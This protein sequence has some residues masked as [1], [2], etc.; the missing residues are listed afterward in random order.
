[1]TVGSG[2]RYFAIIDSVTGK[3]SFF[4]FTGNTGP[5]LTGLTRL[6][7]A[8][9]GDYS[10]IVGSVTW[11]S[12]AWTIAADGMGFQG[13]TEG[14]I[15]SGSLIIETNAKGVPI[16]RGLGLGE[17]A[18]VAGYGKLPNGKSMASRTN[19][20][21]PHGAAFANGIEVSYGAAAFKRPDTL[22]PNYV[23]YVGARSQ[24]G[25]PVVS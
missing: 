10:T 22:T 2:T 15:N 7:S 4:S 20:I 3:V 13:I 17:M 1:M 16:F 19:Y 24:Y 11:N 5:L 8:T 6:G 18:L 23:L 9:T 25:M 14:A 12:G 21:A